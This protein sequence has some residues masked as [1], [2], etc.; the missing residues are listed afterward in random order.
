MAVN[1]IGQVGMMGGALHVTVQGRPYA[2][3]GIRR[4]DGQGDAA[5]RPFHNAPV[6]EADIRRFLPNWQ[7]LNGTHHTAPRAGL[8]AE[9]RADD[10]PYRVHLI[11]DANVQE[12]AVVAQFVA[13][14]V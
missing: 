13:D 9:S 5:F 12:T 11:Y 1:G 14:L 6:T 7:N 4:I 3:L 10:P 8:P 2:G